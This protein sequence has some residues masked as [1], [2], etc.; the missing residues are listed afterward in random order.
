MNRSRIRFVF[1]FLAFAFIFLFFT[2]AILNQLPDARRFPGF[3]ITSRLASSP[4]HPIVANQSDFDW[5]LVAFHSIS[6]PES[7]HSASV[8]SGRVCFLLDYFGFSDP[9]SLG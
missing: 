3:D 1:F 6:A 8:F 4:I 2:T 7:G 9:F 5:P